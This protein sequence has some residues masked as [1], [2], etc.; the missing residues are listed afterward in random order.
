MTRKKTKKSADEEIGTFLAV[1][2][3]EALAIEVLRLSNAIDDIWGA[4]GSEV[5]QTDRELEAGLG[6]AM[7]TLNNLAYALIKVSSR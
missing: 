1:D 6:N 4:V 5:F 7:T 3:R 2:A